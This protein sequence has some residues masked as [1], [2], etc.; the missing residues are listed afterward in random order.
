MIAMLGVILATDEIL[1]ISFDDYL[2]RVY[3][4]V[5]VRQ[6]LAPHVN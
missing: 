5:D 4:I 6:E 3:V 2:A 1:I